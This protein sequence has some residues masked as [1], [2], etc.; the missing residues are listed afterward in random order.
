MK[1]TENMSAY[2]ADYNKISYDRISLYIPKGERDEIRKQADRLGES[3][4]AFIYRAI[5]ERMQKSAVKQSPAP[6]G[7]NAEGENTEG[8]STQNNPPPASPEL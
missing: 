5:V 1:K 3:L 6:E 4:N 8:E 7:E 2:K